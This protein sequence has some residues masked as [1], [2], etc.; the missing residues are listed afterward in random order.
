MHLQLVQHSHRLHCSLGPV[1]WSSDHQI[2]SIDVS[3]QFRSIYA[4]AMVDEFHVRV[5]VHRPYTMDRD[6]GRRYITRCTIMV[7]KPATKPGSTSFPRLSAFPSMF[8]S[9]LAFPNI[10]CQFLVSVVT[11]PAGVDRLVQGR[12][13]TFLSRK[14]YQD[15]NIPVPGTDLTPIIDKD[16]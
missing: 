16:P 3:S 1:S 2:S 15:S 5:L 6:Q 10:H 11:I 9:L 8:Q 7:D 12:S 13:G 14:C 4:V